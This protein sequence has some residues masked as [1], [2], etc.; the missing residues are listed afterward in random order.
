MT[1][2]LKN[3]SIQEL[4]VYCNRNLLDSVLGYWIYN[5][6]IFKNVRGLNHVKSNASKRLV[7]PKKV[8]KIAVNSCL[9]LLKTIIYDYLDSASLR[10][11][12][13]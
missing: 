1:A 10:K 6:R 8:L 4:G 12:Y 9:P 3:N 2:R 11:Q 5:Y 13:F 7:I